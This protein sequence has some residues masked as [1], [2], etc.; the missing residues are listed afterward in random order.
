M[1]KAEENVHVYDAK[2]DAGSALQDFFEGDC[3]VVATRFFRN[4]V[5]FQQLEEVVIPQ[6]LQGGLAHRKVMHIWSAG[7]SDG[8]E[9]YSLA[10]A[11]RRTLNQLGHKGIR[12]QVRG[13]DLSR[14]Q[15]DM[16]R[17]GVYRVGASDNGVFSPYSDFFTQLSPTLWEVKDSIRRMVEFA[18]ENITE[19]VPEEP[20]DLLV[21]SLV[22]LY[23]EPNYQKEILQHLL[24]TLRGDGFFYVAPVSS[25]WMRTQGFM[26]VVKGTNL[27]HRGQ[28]TLPAG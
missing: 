25:R 15:L 24:T 20:Y 16:A 5:L 9:T 1:A 13:S 21:C 19:A 10:V 18:V 2:L 17:E 3:L 4:K 14:P 8:R 6:L 26:S 11:A 22:L 12:L 28:V 23:Y 7:C 27:Y